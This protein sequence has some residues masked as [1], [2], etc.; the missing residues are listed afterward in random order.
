MRCDVKATTMASTTESITKQPASEC[1]E[2][3]QRYQLALTTPITVA[4]VPLLVCSPKGTAVCID[5]R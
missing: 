4:V 2:A 3:A 1:F 5:A